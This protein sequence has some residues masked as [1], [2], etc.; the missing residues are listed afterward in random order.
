M[1]YTLSL[2][3]CAL[4]TE[5]VGLPGWVWWNNQMI[6]NCQKSPRKPPKN[7]SR[8]DGVRYNF[9]RHGPT[10]MNP[11]LSE[12][13]IVSFNETTKRTYRWNLYHSYLFIM[14]AVR[15]FVVIAALRQ[16]NILLNK[17]PKVC[18]L[19]RRPPGSVYGE[20]L[21]IL[22]FFSLCIYTFIHSFITTCL[23]CSMN[24]V[25][26]SSHRATQFTY[27]VRRIS[28]SNSHLHHCVVLCLVIDNYGVCS[29]RITTVETRPWS[30]T[31]AGQ[32]QVCCSSVALAL[33]RWQGQCHW[34]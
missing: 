11:L 13:A 21:W 32:G 26:S 9:P 12:N 33:H 23:C 28:I 31:S 27:D 19:F 34:W 2:H 1:H 5:R 22:Y 17:L 14:V 24:V 8:S 7:W 10:L 6:P 30:S 29:S 3:H 16:T 20:E 25:N 15:W 4:H 18:F